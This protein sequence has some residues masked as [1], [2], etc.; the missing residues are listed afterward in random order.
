MA[1]KPAELAGLKH[2][3]SIALGND[4][5]FALFA[6]EDAFVVDVE[7]LHHKNPISPYHGKTLAGV[8]RRSII[9]GNDVDFATPAGS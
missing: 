2:K 3:G 9:A 6:P 5:D 8:V 7:K 1:V 4:A